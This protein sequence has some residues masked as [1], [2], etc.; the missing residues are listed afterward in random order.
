MLFE[1]FMKSLES[2]IDIEKMHEIQKLE[3]TEND[4]NCEHDCD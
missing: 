3:T 2:R 4:C 1:A